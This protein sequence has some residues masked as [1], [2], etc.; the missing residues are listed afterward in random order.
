MRIAPLIIFVAVLFVV[1]SCHQEGI[2]IPKNFP[3]TNRIFFDSVKMI[4]IELGQKLFFDTRLSRDSTLSCISCHKPELAF[5]DG[6]ERSKGIFGNFSTRNSSTLI[7]VGYNT[8]FMADMRAT[9]IEIQPM[10]P[11]HDTNEMAMTIQEV[12][13]R[14]SN[15]KLLQ[16]MS[17]KAYKEPIN[18]YT[19]TRSLAAFMKS[20][21]SADTKYDVQDNDTR[22]NT[23][24]KGENRGK[25]LFFGKGKCNQCHTAPLFT[26][27]KHYNIGIEDSFSN[28]IGKQGATHK[29]EDRYRFKVPTLRNISITFP[30]FHNG[31]LKSLEDAVSY[32]LAKERKTMDFDPPKLNYAEKA[33]LILFLRTL[34]D[35]SYIKQ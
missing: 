23:F 35:K 3:K 33:D 21:L 10:I 12:V 16:S 6:V 28:D 8:S 30:Y 29:L 17:M 2:K 27:Y 32:H 31:K 25:A 24:T 20:L 26:N 4:S 1:N 19:I 9:N 14:L 5:T 18:S 15:D 34:T 11:I 13:V 7:N 22:T